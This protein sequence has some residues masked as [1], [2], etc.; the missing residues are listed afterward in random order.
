MKVKDLIEELKKY[1]PEAETSV[2]VHCF[3][4]QFSMTW[5][6]EGDGEDVTKEE[7]KE[8]N[9]YVDRLCQNEVE[10]HPKQNTGR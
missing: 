6:G 4:E 9:F 3:K 1:N 8:V 7:C 2:I 10:T 5:G